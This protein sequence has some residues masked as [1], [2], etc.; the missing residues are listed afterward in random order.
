MYR[1]LVPRIPD[2]LRSWLESGAAS[3][4]VAAHAGLWDHQDWIVLLAHLGGI[5]PGNVEPEAVGLVLEALKAQWLNLSRWQASEEA[6][7][8]V[9]A[10]QGVWH[11]QDWLTL[12]ITLRRSEFWPLNFEAVGLELEQARLRCARSAAGRSRVSFA[13]GSA[14]TRANGTTRLDLLLQ[15]LRLSSFWPLNEAALGQLL[16]STAVQWRRPP[17]RWQESGTPEALGEGTPGSLV[18]R[19]LAGIAGHIPVVGHLAGGCRRGGP[20]P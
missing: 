20:G 5:V 17:R 8:W 10:C 11:H 12:L 7:R 3:R 2:N 4:W 14:P 19:R 16:E 9:A 15:G 6:D 18:P 13:A 1:N